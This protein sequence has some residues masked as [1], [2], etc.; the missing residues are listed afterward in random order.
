[1]SS[2]E[3]RAE[4]SEVEDEGKSR[5]LSSS[6]KRIVVYLR[7]KPT[8]DWSE[9]VLIRDEEDAK[10]K[11]DEKKKKT[12]SFEVDD[13]SG[14]SANLQQQQQQQN[15]QSAAQAGSIRKYSAIHNFKFDE[16]LPL[17]SSKASTCA[18][19]ALF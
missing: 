12:V 9:R 19:E 18:L 8:A 4:E 15:Q 5:P 3:G 1:M 2:D 7:F 17:E 6:S 16:I 13:P 11:E 10:N 14:G